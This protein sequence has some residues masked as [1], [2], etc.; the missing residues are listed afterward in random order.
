VDITSISLYPYLSTT[1][2]KTRDPIKIPMDIIDIN[3]PALILLIPY[4]SINDGRIDPRVVK[5]IPKISIPK[6][7]AEKDNFFEY[8]Y[9]L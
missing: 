7:A 2:P 9:F 1:G 3:D 4:C 8:I 6:Q 5:T